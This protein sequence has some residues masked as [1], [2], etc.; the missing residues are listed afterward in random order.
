M[1]YVGIRRH[2]GDFGR[3]TNGTRGLANAKRVYRESG[4][5]DGEIAGSLPGSKVIYV[6]PLFASSTCNLLGELRCKKK[7]TCPRL[8]SNSLLAQRGVRSLIPGVT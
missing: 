7:H 1:E 4:E 5:R 3:K 8:R 6:F 2:G